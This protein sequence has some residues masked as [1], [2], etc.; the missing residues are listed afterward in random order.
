MMRQIASKYKDGG[1]RQKHVKGYIKCSLHV[2]KW[3]KLL[4]WRKKAKQLN[5][6]CLN[7]NLYICVK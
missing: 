5:P 2:C 7:I 6:L 4:E 3:L 1:P